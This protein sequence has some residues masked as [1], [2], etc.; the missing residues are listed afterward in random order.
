MKI[1]PTISVVLPNY[2][3]A[4]ELKTSLA[5]IV[6]Q[7]EPFDEVIV[8]DDG[9]TDESLDVIAGFARRCPQLRLLKS[10]KQTG[11][12]AAVNRGIEAASCDY[13]ALAS[14]DE[15]VASN[16]AESFREA[17][18]AFPDVKLVVSCYSE[19][20]GIAETVKS[21]GLEPGLGMWYANCED[22][23][24]VDPSQFRALLRKD[25]VW[26]SIN[27]AIFQ[28]NALREAG[29]FDPTLQWHSDWFLIYT[30]ALRHGFCAI[31][32]TLATFRISDSSYSARGMRDPVQQN[33]VMG[34][35]IEKMNTA[36]FTDI[37]HAVFAFPATISPFVRILG[38]SLLSQPRHFGFL[39]RLIG[40]WIWQVAKLRRPAPLLRLRTRIANL[41]LSP[42]THSSGHSA[43]AMDRARAF[44]AKRLQ[45]NSQ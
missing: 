3:H 6:G 5:A 38:P 20:D 32:K 15:K 13:I 41:F 4:I 30:I 19:W 7:S 25:F 10:D 37:G 8:I 33:R 9:S 39:F 42:N 35:L 1:K 44:E 18:V 45:G 14:A 31:P 36:P 40:W 27:S 17:I 16:M 26:L 11:V 24:L 22:A 29:G 21:Y 12:A 43:D 34:R 28:R 2:N 23:F